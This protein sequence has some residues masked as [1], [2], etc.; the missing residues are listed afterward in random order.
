[1]VFG[2]AL[3]LEQSS[4]DQLMVLGDYLHGDL[5]TSIGLTGVILSPDELLLLLTFGFWLGRSIATRRPDFTGGQL[6]WPMLLFLGA[7]VIGFVRG[8]AGGGPLNVALWESRFIFYTVMCYFLATNTIRTRRH[9]RMLTTIFIV[10]T[11]SF[12]IEGAYRRMA[13]IDTGQIVHIPE[14]WYA[15]EDV[16]FLGSLI[17][18]SLAQMIYGG[19]RWQRWLG[20]VFIVVA[21]YTLLA[22]ERRAGYIGIVVA[23]LAILV[24]LLRT[25]RT[26]FFTIGL[27]IMLAGAVYLPLFWN[28]QGIAA[29]PARAIRSLRDPDPRDAMSNLTRE[30]EKINVLTTIHDNPVLGVGFGRKFEQVV[31]I[32]DISF[33]VFWDLEPHHAVLWVWL[34]TGVFGFIIFLT[35]MGSAIAR[36]AHSVKVLG[37]PHL[38]ATAILAMCAVI[39]T[40]TFAYVDLGLTSGRVTIFL[41]TL[42]GALAVLDRL[43]PPTAAVSPVKG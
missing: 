1:V 38:R 23:L 4:P 33:F 26:A 22:S 14:F 10:A 34:K 6:G 27:P 18:F 32:P 21:G 37:D 5:S 8:V 39:T 42:L 16:I 28:A 30:L 11:A 13:L 9:L 15:H 25:K 3:L 2:L 24:V 35:L 20:P 29:Q 31:A 43:P 19:P 40:V 17:L 41:G 7:L 36:A 12:A